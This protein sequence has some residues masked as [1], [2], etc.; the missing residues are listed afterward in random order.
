MTLADVMGNSGLAIFAEIA[1]V[2][3]IAAFLVVM[4]R[5][6]LPGRRRELEEAARLPLDDHELVTPRSGERP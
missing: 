1:M 2:L 6:F 4:V 3:F 5:L